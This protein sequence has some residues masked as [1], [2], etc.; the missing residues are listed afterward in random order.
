VVL[1][2][3]VA[4]LTALVFCCSP[5]GA[6]SGGRPKCCAPRKGGRQYSRAQRGLPKSILKVLSGCR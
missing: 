6:L 1:P 5:L 2:H 4:A 3:V